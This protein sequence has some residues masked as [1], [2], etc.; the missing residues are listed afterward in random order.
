MCRHLPV[1]RNG[2][3]NVEWDALGCHLFNN[4][5]LC[6]VKPSIHCTILACSWAAQLILTWSKISASL[7]TVC[8]AV[9]RGERGPIIRSCT[10]IRH[11]FDMYE[12][13]V[14]WCMFL[15]SW[16]RAMS[17]I[18]RA[19]GN[20]M[21]DTIYGGKVGR[22]CVPLWCFLLLLLWLMVLSC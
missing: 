18:P 13:L 4:R 11:I 5:S 1:L 8:L 14:A 6:N 10:A 17:W 21:M 15:R 3:V 19:S 22:A 2:Q 9:Q 12:I 20:M 7:G 16:S